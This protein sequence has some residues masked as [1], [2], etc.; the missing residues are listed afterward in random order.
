MAGKGHTVRLIALAIAT[1]TLVSVVAGTASASPSAT[2]T[3]QMIA[4]GQGFALRLTINVPTVLRSAL[5]ATIVQTMAMTDGAISTVTT[6]AAHTNA[7]MGV[8]TTPVLSALMDK[9]K[10]SATLAQNSGPSNLLNIDQAGIKIAVMP[11][12]STVAMPTGN[13]VLAKSDSAMAHVG[14]GGLTGA[15]P[16]AL[17]PV[18]STLDTALGTKNGTVG[19]VAGTVGNTLVD[20][21]GQLN[22]AT[23]SSPEQTAAITAAITQ[24]TTSLS[25]LT[26]MLPRL[27]AATDIVSLDSITS[28]QTISRTGN[29]VT[30]SVSNT[31]HNLNILNGLVKIDAITSNATATAGGVVGSAT[32]TTKAPVFKVSIAQDALTALLDQNGLNI[33]GTVGSNLPPALQ[34]PVNTALGTVNGLVNQLAGVSVVFGKGTT[35]TAPDGTAAA[36]QVAATVIT[37]NPP[38]LIT[39]GLSSKE[40]PLITIELVG[41]QAD[42]ASRVG[43]K[44]GTPAL[45]IDL[46]TAGNSSLPRTGAELP[47]VGFLATA[48]MGGALVVRRRRSALS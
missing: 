3:N 47:A 36:S 9:Y 48:L 45:P 4:N 5:G 41:A 28:N 23:G 35:S 22:Q 24:L 21:I 40:K 27:A 17:A 19:Q 37:V 2:P 15:L 34:G 1:G 44:S 10:S 38:A 13:G 6:P 26:D 33:G 29:S 42:A 12:S 39:A 16:L 14:I 30:S 46:P 8:G 18:A 7:F 32:A 31:V 25:G 20:T 43:A 11:Q